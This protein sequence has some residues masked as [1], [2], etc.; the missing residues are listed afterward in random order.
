MPEPWMEIRNLQVE[1]FKTIGNSIVKKVHETTH[2]MHW[3]RPVVIEE[4]AR[5][6][7]K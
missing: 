2:L 4:Y 3:D 5:T 6:W 7:F 1:E